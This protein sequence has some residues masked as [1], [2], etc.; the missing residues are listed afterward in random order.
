M[1][2]PVAPGSCIMSPMADASDLNDDENW[3]GGFYELSI[4]LGERDDSRLEKAL[5]AVW[6][7]ASV[8]GCFAPEYQFFSGSTPARLVGHNPVSLSLRSLEGLGHL[9]GVVELPDERQIVCGTV[10]IRE[11]D[12]PDWLDFYL[13]LG[14]LGRTDPRVRGFPFGDDYGVATFPWRQP[15]DHWLADIG[16]RVHDEVPYR[17]GLIGCEVSGEVYADQLVAGVPDE[18]DIGYLLPLNG[19]LAYREANR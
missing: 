9:R 6:R 5:L 10:A 19:K 17:L 2:A 18:H 12:G 11:D 7:H 13:P 16:S 1:N 14:A 15:I 3:S 4:E 8:Q